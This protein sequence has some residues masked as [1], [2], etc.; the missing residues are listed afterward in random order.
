MSYSD[1][2]AAS[3]KSSSYSSLGASTSNN[4]WMMWVALI[5]AFLIFFF[6]LGKK[7]EG[8]FTGVLGWLYEY[9]SFDKMLAEALLK[10]SYIFLA[11][12]VTL[13]S[14]TMIGVSFLLFLLYLMIT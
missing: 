12:W 5:A 3:S 8:K 11:L 9:L 2:L 14:F 13:T 1:L 6:F 4:S 7:N 10:I